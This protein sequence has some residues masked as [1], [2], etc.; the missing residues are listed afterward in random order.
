[1]HILQKAIIGTVSGAL[2]G[3]LTS[4]GSTLYFRNED[5]KE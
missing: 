5:K 3:G 1:M 2:A 4:F